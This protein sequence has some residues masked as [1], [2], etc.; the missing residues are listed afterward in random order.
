MAAMM[1]FLMQCPSCE[2]MTPARV[3]RDERM[4]LTELVCQQC[5]YSVLVRDSEFKLRDGKFKLR[6][7]ESELRD[8]EFKLRG[9]PPPDVNQ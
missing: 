3:S 6:D 2:K 9:P 5:G 4:Q 7:S 1:K 8:S